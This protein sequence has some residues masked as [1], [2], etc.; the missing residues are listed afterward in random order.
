V[1]TREKDPVRG[2]TLA[3]KSNATRIPDLARGPTPRIRVR[4]PARWLF[5]WNRKCVPFEI[6]QWD[7]VGFSETWRG[8]RTDSELIFRTDFTRIWCTDFTRIL[9][10]GRFNRCAIR[11]DCPNSSPLVT[12]YTYKKN[13]ALVCAAFGFPVY[14]LM[15]SFEWKGQ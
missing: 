13:A 11:F 14:N 4:S 6:Q 8:G 7:K 9:I 5:E 2:L 1:I 3:A 15:K 10:S 12:A